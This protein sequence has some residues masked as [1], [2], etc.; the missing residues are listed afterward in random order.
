MRISSF[1]SS[2]LLNLNKT[3]KKIS[4]TFEQLSSGKRINSASDDPAGMSLAVS[5]NSASRSLNTINRGITDAQGALNTAQDGLSQTLESLQRARDLAVQ[6]ANGTLSDSDRANLQQEYDQTLQN[7]DQISSQT[8]FGNTNLLDGSYK[9]DVPTSEGGSPTSIS[10]DSSSSSALG[11]Q[12]TGISTQSSAQDALENIDNAIQQVSSQMSS[13]GG[14]QNALDSSYDANSIQA[15]N[16]SAAEAQISEA[17]MAE[18]ASELK[19]QQIQ[20]EAQ[21]AAMR[22]EKSSKEPIVKKLLAKI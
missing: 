12:A 10:I 11:I 22:A 13:I 1:D 8:S 2:S 6:A 20:Q 5:L 3:N 4:K 17:D 21:M 16:I 15:E 9:V 14:Y 19:K 18:V 7:I